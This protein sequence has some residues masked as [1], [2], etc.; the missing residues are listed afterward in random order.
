[1]TTQ[2]ASSV[3]PDALAASVEAAPYQASARP[4]EGAAP[5]A[6]PS[7]PYFD[8]ECECWPIDGIPLFR[9][10]NAECPR[11][12][13]EEAAPEQPAP[14]YDDR[15]VRLALGWGAANLRL[16]LVRDA[17][18]DCCEADRVRILAALEDK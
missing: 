8:D 15:A 7:A 17:L 16:A 5:S 10:T 9:R 13:P 4:A 2:T 6:A 14:D 18:K 11:H 12:R 1:M 3:S